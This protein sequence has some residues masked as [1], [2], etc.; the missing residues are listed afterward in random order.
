M[1]K[2]MT[3][4][5]RL[6]S[7]EPGA[8]VPEFPPSILLEPT[9]ACNIK[10]RMC[11]IHGEGVNKSREIGFIK[12]DLWTG[13]IE[14]IGSW[15]SQVNLDIHGAGE[16][17]LHPEFFD[18]LSLAKSKGN[19][20]V[21]F[22]CNA[23][24]LDQEKAR[25]VIELGVDWICFSV[26]GAQKEVFEYYRRGAHLETVERNI[27]YLLSLRKQGKPQ[28][29]FNMVNHDEADLA[30]FIDTW[31]GLVD[32]LSISI[33]RPVRREDQERLKLLKPCPLLYQQLVIGWPGKTGLCCEDLWG[34][35]ITGEIP[36]ASLHDIWHDKVLRKARR[37]HE[38]G[39]QDNIDLCRTCNT[40]H[41]HQYEE[42]AEVRNEC[43]T[44]IRRELPALNPELAIPSSAK[45]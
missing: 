7:R 21:G 38:E 36:A 16:P 26:D 11:P 19:I 31:A 2:L 3:K 27:K 15:P 17:L 34:D 20:T 39:R 1:I 44:L 8:F 12:K 41:F 43:T 28:I 22:L 4:I 9:N 10:C 14:E 25:A 24:L 45:R 30:L 29:Y 37:L 32:S 13:I 18:M 6:I 42:K 33:K 35:M 40:I 5:R 23:T